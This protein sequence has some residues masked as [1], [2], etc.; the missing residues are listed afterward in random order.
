MTQPNAEGNNQKPPWL[1]P[2]IILFVIVGI[3][4]VGRKKEEAI[5]NP[6]V[7]LAIITVGVFAFAAA[8][9]YIGIKLGSPGFASFFGGPTT[10]TEK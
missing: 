1:L 9:R 7:D 4:V 5:E 3:G 2:A 10:S 6:L 8:F